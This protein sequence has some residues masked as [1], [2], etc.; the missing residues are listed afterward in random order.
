MSYMFNK[1]YNLKEIK[2]ITN[3]NTTKATNMSSMFKECSKL[4]YVDLTNN[5]LNNINKD[6][7]NQLNEEINKNINSNNE[8]NFVVKKYVVLFKSVDK[9]INFSL[10]CEN[11]DIFTK[12]ENDL[13]LKYPYLKNKNISYFLNEKE[14]NKTSTL[15][16][17][18]IKNGDTILIK[19]IY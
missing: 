1:C 15:S 12:L 4:E 19:E 16:E 10:K 8:I 17:N 7:T 9:T 5:I 2:G 13:Y 14:I 6:L 3:F 18:G 11:L